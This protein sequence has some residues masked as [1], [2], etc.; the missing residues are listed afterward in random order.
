MDERY[1][2]RCLPRRSVDGVVWFSKSGKRSVVVYNAYRLRTFSGAHWRVIDLGSRTPWPISFD[3]YAATMAQLVGER[4][5]YYCRIHSCA[6]HS[7][8]RIA[9]GLN[10]A[11]E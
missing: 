7:F 5:F 2:F 1:C 9:G 8:H 4:G 6:R 3:L 10:Y 11:A